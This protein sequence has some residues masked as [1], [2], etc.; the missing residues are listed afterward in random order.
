MRR[1]F[2]TLAASLSLSACCAHALCARGDVRLCVDGRTPLSHCAARLLH[3]ADCVVAAAAVLGENQRQE[4]EP[5]R[6]SAGGGSLANAA[7]DL[8]LMG[9]ALADGDWGAAT[10]PLAAV[11][12]S[13]AA[14]AASFDGVL[15]D[16][17][18]LM[19]ASGECEDAAS[20]TGCISLAAAAGP[21]LQAAG[22]LIADAGAA[23][24]AH[25]EGLLFSG[26]TGAHTEAGRQ[27]VA[28]GEATA[29]A[30]RELRDAGVRL[31]GGWTAA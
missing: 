26:A 13:L 6:L 19:G 27:M 15:D 2:A 1:P 28:A 5:G 24:R 18:A 16:G 25:G 14:A 8:E 30:A 11:A 10:E 7:R 9:Q 22:E 17:G 20:C 29:E 4:E 12:V 23:L 3:G 31:E 21:N